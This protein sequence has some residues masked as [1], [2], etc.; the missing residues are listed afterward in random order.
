MPSVMITT[1]SVFR[2][3]FVPLHYSDFL[4]AK[5]SGRDSCNPAMAHGRMTSCVSVRMKYVSPKADAWEEC[6]DAAKRAGSA[7]RPLC[8]GTDQ[9]EWQNAFCLSTWTS[10]PANGWCRILWQEVDAQ[11]SAG[12]AIWMCDVHG[13]SNCA[14]LCCIVVHKVCTCLCG[15]TASSA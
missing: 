13:I 8:A 11:P 10:S 2:Q 15:L 6:R 14:K 3:A 4:S 9:L 1:T 12:F 7:G 5:H